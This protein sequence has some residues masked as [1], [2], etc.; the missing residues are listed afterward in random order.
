MDSNELDNQIE[1][2][3]NSVMVE[4]LRSDLFHKDI[5]LIND[6]NFESRKLVES[7]GK[8]DLLLERGRS[9]SNR[10]IEEDLD[11]IEILHQSGKVEL[12][13]T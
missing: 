1:V 13:A 5:N 2:L 3:F 4:A 7:M 10:A 11:C 6:N 9:D 8:G 12:F